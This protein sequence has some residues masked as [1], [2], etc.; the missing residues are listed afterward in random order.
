[1][2]QPGEIKKNYKFNISYEK[3]KKKINVNICYIVNN[4]VLKNI[5]KSFLSHIENILCYAFKLKYLNQQNFYPTLKKHNFF[6]LN[7][8]YIYVRVSNY[9]LKRYYVIFL[10]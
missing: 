8:E 4:K 6:L 10:S 9:T 5:L 7:I 2:G 1:M 3:I